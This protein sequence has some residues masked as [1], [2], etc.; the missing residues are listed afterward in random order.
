[1]ADIALAAL[2]VFITQCPSFP[3][4]QRAMEKSRS[5]SNA[6]SLF[7]VREIPSGNHIPK[8]LDPICPDHLYG[9]FNDLFLTADQVGFLDIMRNLSVHNSQ[10]IALDGTWYCSSQS[11][12]IHCPNFS[13]IHH[14]NGSRTHF[15][16]AITPVIVS[17]GCSQVIPLRPEFISSQD[18]HDKQDCEISASKRWLASQLFLSLY[19]E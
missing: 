10:L 18:D 13:C 2:L 17:P 11:E 8:T 4:F 15:H 9:I 7:H 6:H 12:N 14:S 16:S 19:Q 5:V 1:M 3:S